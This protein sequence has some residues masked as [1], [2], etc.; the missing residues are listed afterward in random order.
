M[1]WHIIKCQMC[2]ERPPIFVAFPPYKDIPPHFVCRECYRPFIEYLDS[3]VEEIYKQEREY[4]KTYPGDG[5]RE[6]IREITS[7]YRKFITELKN[8]F[9]RFV[10]EWDDSQA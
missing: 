1:Y 10:K 5:H 7:E 2:E 6:I 8:E 4:R 3:E 9:I